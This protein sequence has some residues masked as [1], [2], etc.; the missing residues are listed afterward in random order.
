[1]SNPIVGGKKSIAEKPKSKSLK[2]LFRPRNLLDI[3][4]EIKA[5]LEQKGLVARWVD[6]KQM[7][8]GGNVHKNH[9]QVYRRDAAKVSSE[10]QAFGLPPDGTVRRGTLVLAV[11]PKEIQEAHREALQEKADSR[12]R[13]IKK[14]GR[15]LQ[16]EA[17][18]FGLNERVKDDIEID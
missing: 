10:A 15:E 8:D 4:E 3:P 12:V 17:R 18:R 11:R 1:M 6:S 7:A 13:S 5:E 9:W 2:E 14:Q 16:A